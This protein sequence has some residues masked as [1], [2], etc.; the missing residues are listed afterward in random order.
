LC[1]ANRGAYVEKSEP[2]ARA[3]HPTRF[4]FWRLARVALEGGD[5]QAG[6]GAHTASNVTA[7]AVTAEC[8]GRSASGSFS[9]SITQHFDRRLERSP[10]QRPQLGDGVAV[11]GDDDDFA[12][13]P[14]IHDGR[15]IVPKLP[16][17]NGSG[18]LQNS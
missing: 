9:R 4:F 13:F 8:T 1:G 11:A 17:C 6:G 16:L 15:G 5:W 14:R 7:S 10:L 3:L 18:H 2:S 12:R